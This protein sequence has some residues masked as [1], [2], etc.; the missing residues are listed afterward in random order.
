MKEK[1]SLK[2][3]EEID[4]TSQKNKI[5]EKIK[6]LNSKIDNLKNKLLNKAYLTKAPKNIVQDDKVLLRDLSIEENK[7]RSI[8][9]SIS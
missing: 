9:S 6:I 8:V 1:L 7:L 4:I 3:D 2:F 5:S